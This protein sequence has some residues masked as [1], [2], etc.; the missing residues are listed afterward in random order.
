MPIESTNPTN[1]SRFAF[2]K[3]HP[4]VWRIA[5]II[6]CGATLLILAYFLYV[7]TGLRV[8]A[9]RPTDG[10]ADTPD[11]FDIIVFDFSEPVIA[12]SVTFEISPNRIVKT[13][14]PKE[15]PNRIS[16]MPALVGWEPDVTYTITITQ[17]TAQDG[18]K[19]R[20]KVSSTYKNTYTFGEVLE[21]AP[22]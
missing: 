15:Y 5:V 2:I 14:A 6:L 19:L 8:R 11:R 12:D 20:R 9:V 3:N 16:I 18:T 7:S 1:E 13:I 4:Y 22:Y 10:I 17:A 21:N